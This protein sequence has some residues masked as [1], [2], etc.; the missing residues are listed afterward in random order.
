[1]IKLKRILRIAL[2]ISA[3][4]AMLIACDDLS[5]SDTDTLDKT[6]T[7]AKYSLIGKWEH[8]V[9]NAEYKETIEITSDDKIIIDVEYGTYSTNATW[10]IT[11]VSDNT[12]KCK[13]EN[14]VSVEIKYR[15]LTADSVEF[16]INNVWAKYKVK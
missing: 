12:I 1:M 16:S 11:S 5:S 13:T 8:S 7:D 2:A 15:N 3:V 9:T 4:S 6:T 14:D 10:T